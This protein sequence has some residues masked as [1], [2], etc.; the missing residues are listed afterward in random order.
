MTNS[1]D[2]QET[3]GQSPRC[4]QRGWAWAVAIALVLAVF[5]VFGRCVGFD[6]VNFDDRASICENPHVSHGLTKQGIAWAFTQRDAGQ[7]QPLTWLSLMA[8]REVFGRLPRWLH[9]TQPGWFHFTNVLLHAVAAVLLL[10][11]LWQMTGRLWPAAF[12]AALFAIHPLRAESVAWITERKDVSERR[13]LHAHAGGL[14]GVHEACRATEGYIPIFV[15]R[16]LGQSPANVFHRPL[17]GG[18]DLPGPGID[19][20]T[21]AGHGA[22]RVAAVGLLAVGCMA[23]LRGNFKN[24]AWL[25]L[26]KIPLLAI[27]GVSCRITYWAQGDALISSAIIPW[28]WRVGNAMLSYVG[29]LGDFFY[30]AHLAVAYPRRDVHLPPWQVAGAVALLA[31]VTAAAVAARRKYPYGIVGWLWYL[32][33]MLPVI[34]LVQFGVQAEA[35]RFTYLPQIGL[36]I[37][38]AWAVAEVGRRWPSQ[39]V[40]CGLASTAALVALA[41]CAW[42]QTATCGDDESLWTRPWSATGGMASPMV[43]SG[44]IRAGQGRIKEALDEFHKALEINPCDADA[45]GYLGVTLGNLGQID[46]AIAEFRKALDINPRDAGT[47]RNL[48]LALE[49]L[50]RL[51]EAA[52][53]YRTALEFNPDDDAACNRLAAIRKAKP[54]RQAEQ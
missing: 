30:P 22:V 32:G 39:R 43:I 48:G 51:R 4:G 27:A 37:A 33:M 23:V 17:R 3:S 24:L 47:H 9:F 44:V 7:W 18:G 35:D 41:V 52:D 25:V 15:K 28:L 34:G 10:L 26:E 19:G 11:V 6:F 8:D 13:L 53:E 5:A 42:R 29:Y 12:A 46:E 31:A 40:L 45:H 38:A 54:R 50:G 16:K 14:C 21:G 49:G 20:Q 36:G 2:H 1:S